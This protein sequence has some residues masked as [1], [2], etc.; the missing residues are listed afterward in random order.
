MANKTLTHEALGLSFEVPER[1]TVGQHLRYRSAIAGAAGEDM[2]GRHWQGAKTLILEWES[3]HL[4][5]YDVDLETVT[6]IRAADTVS[7]A[8]NLVAAYISSLDDDDPN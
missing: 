8:C 3:P 6:S 7:I 2:Y 1:P 5:D 4:P